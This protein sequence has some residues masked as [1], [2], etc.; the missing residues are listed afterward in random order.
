MCRGMYAIE[1]SYLS[2]DLPPLS[3]PSPQ[4]LAPRACA[5]TTLLKVYPV[6]SVGMVSN[7]SGSWYSVSSQPKTFNACSH[8]WRE[9][10]RKEKKKCNQRK[11]QLDI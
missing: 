6:F 7:E 5:A 8:L 10:R 2:Y 4:L 11:V 1:Y 9:R 3:W